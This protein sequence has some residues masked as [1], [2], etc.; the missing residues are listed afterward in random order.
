MV[1]PVLRN[2]RTVF[3]ICVETLSACDA[4]AKSWMAYY[5]FVKTQRLS[6]T[7]VKTQRAPRTSVRTLKA[8][9][10]SVKTLRSSYTSEATLGA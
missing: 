9:D 5:A 6:R 2:L 1:V 10:I 7:S 4:S 8:S 3:R